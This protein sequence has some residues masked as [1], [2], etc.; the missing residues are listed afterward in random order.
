MTLIRTHT[1]HRGLQLEEALIF[2]QGCA[3]AHRGR[4]A[5]AGAGARRAARRPAPARRDRPARAVG[6]GGGAPLHPP[7]PEE[8]L[9][10]QRPVPARLVHDE[11]QPAAQREGR[12]PAGA[13]RPAPAA[14][15][16]DRP[17]RARGDPHLRP[18]A[19]DADRD[20]G[21][22]DV[23]W[24]RRAWRAGWADDH[25]RRHRGSRRAARPGAGAGTRLMAPIR[26]PPM[27]AAMRS[28][29]FPPTMRPRRSGGPARE[30]RYATSPRSW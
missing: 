15:G 17:G 8:L 25:P 13:W 20:A 1:G 22:G 21:G 19:E 26:R 6:T 12:A 7:Q 11:A 27:P 3:G 23:A 5:R 24:R 9:H 29:P 4:S 28:K 16:L 14:A 30:A 2:E 10:R 18:L